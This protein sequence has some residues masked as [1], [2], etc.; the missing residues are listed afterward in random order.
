MSSKSTRRDFLKSVKYTGIAASAFTV[1]MG[2]N[3]V[4]SPSPLP[5]QASD[6]FINPRKVLLW[7]C[8]RR[9]IRESLNAGK[10]KAAI[11]PTGSTEQHN[12]HLAMIQD[13]ASALLIAKETALN[14]YPEVIVT[15]PVPIGISPHWMDRRGTL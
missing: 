4:S 3:A 11:I 12:E 5:K 13:T 10:L 1:G 6:R 7:E 9:E 14:L 8:T 15:T 2:S